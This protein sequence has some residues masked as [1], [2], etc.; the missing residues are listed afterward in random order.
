M[1][2]RR[3]LQ[4]KQNKSRPIVVS[5]R[6]DNHLKHLASLLV[7][8]PLQINITIPSFIDRKRGGEEWEIHL[9]YYGNFFDDL[10]IHNEKPI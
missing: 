2:F 8:T 10:S 4:G 7:G 5:R 3:L 6:Y 1:G 9:W